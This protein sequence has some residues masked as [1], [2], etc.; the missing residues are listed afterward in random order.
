MQ[1]PGCTTTRS[2]IKLLVMEALAPIA[3]SRPMRTPG[4]ITAPALMTVPVPISARGPMTTPGSTVTPLSRRAVG[5]TIAPVA[6]PL[7]SNKDDGRTA[8]GKS[9]RVTS[10]KAR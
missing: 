4:P 1:H 10:T 5:C 6:M 7:A 3:Q 9:L 8:S 2:P